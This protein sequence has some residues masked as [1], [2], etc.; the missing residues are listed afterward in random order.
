[1]TAQPPCM[2]IQSIVPFFRNKE[3]RRCRTTSLSGDVLHFKHCTRGWRQ[4][5][6]F[7]SFSSRSLIDKQAGHRAA[8]PPNANH[9]CRFVFFFLRGGVLSKERERQD[10]TQNFREVKDKKRPS[11]P[12]FSWQT[13][14]HT[15][16]HQ[17]APPE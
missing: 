6:K 11:R 13:D 10:D 2:T 1:M 14:T 12:N 5:G 17:S 3:Q 16:S 15:H 9:G 8:C 7:Q 4:L